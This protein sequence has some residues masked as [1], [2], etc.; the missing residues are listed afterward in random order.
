M[1]CSGT[2][3]RISQQL[4]CP[5]L[6]QYLNDSLVNTDGSIGARGTNSDHERCHPITAR[7]VNICTMVYEQLKIGDALE[8][9]GIPHWCVTL[10]VFR[11]R[12]G[13]TTQESL[14]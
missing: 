5:I 2:A 4:I 6:E 1:I 12:I 14:K 7:G 9:S 3:E 13:S 8:L 11:I 10:S